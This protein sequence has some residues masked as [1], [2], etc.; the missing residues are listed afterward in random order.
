MYYEPSS[1]KFYNTVYDF[2]VDHRNTSYG[3]LE[4]EEE[5]NAHG[6]YTLYQP[7]PE[8]DQELQEIV[9]DGVEFRDG[10]YYRKYLVQAKNL[11]AEDY[12]AVMLKRFTEALNKHL[13]DVAKQR[14]YDNR[15][16]CSLRAG[17]PGVFQAEGIAFAMWMDA[18]NA[19]AYQ[20]WAD[21]RNGVRPIPVSIAAFLAELPTMEWPPSVIPQ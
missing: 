2:R 18:C 6:L 12:A 3:E 16:T 7:L 20:I 8:Y 21:V 15:I 1:E 14:R 13:D 5:R 19:A 17:Y 4:S 11:T 10:Q 9:P